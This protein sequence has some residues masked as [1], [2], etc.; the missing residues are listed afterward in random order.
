MESNDKMAG[1][2]EALELVYAEITGGRG[3]IT[4]QNSPHYLFDDGAEAHTLPAAVN[5]GRTLTR[6]AINQLRQSAG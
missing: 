4:H 6:F 5:Q 3:L 2:L 1:Q